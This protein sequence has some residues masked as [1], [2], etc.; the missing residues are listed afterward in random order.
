MFIIAKHFNGYVIGCH[1]VRDTSQYEIPVSTG[2]QS[3]RSTSRYGVPVGTG[4]QSV[5]D[6]SQY[7]I[8]V[9]NSR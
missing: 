3:V 7:R 6:T 8:P 1:S 9:M 2:Y 5:R 4:Y